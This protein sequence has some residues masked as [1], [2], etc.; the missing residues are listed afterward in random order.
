LE[1]ILLLLTRYLERRNDFWLTARFLSVMLYKE[2]MIA[3]SRKSRRKNLRVETLIQNPNGDETKSEAENASCATVLWLWTM[4]KPSAAL[5]FAYILVHV[6]L[7][8]AVAAAQNYALRGTLS[9]IYSKLFHKYSVRQTSTSIPKRSEFVKSKKAD[10]K[11]CREKDTLFELHMRIRRS[12]FYF[13]I[14]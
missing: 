5:Y 13:S 11:A 14:K 2:I 10:A 8:A 12:V 6:P 1:P 4:Q 7:Q 3:I 9:L